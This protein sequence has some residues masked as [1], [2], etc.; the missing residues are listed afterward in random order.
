MG[1]PNGIFEL[2]RTKNQKVIVLVSAVDR[3]IVP[4]LRFVSG[5]ACSDS[6]ALHIVTDPERARRLAADWMYLGLTWLPLHIQEPTADSLTLSVR[7]AIREESRANERVTVV[8]PELDFP[9]WWHP[10]LH[11]GRS[12]RRIAELLQ[13]LA[14]VTTVIVPFYVTADEP[15]AGGRAG[16]ACEGGTR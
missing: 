9:R 8:V 3:R 6:R 1:T 11:R 14:R 5:L 7:E 2:R 12:A 13:P 15:G 16:P 4:A 10:L